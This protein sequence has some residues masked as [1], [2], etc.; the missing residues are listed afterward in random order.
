LLFLKLE[1]IVEIDG[2]CQVEEVSEP[3]SSLCMFFMVQYLVELHCCSLVIP[4]QLP[5][6]L[7]SS[8]FS[9]PPARARTN[10]SIP[11]ALKQ[12]LH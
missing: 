3:G 8:A 4:E 10:T 9:L 12:D 11:A 5:Q 1:N 7:V 6:V 2:S